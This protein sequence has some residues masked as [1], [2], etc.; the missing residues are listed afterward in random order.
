MCK[1]GDDAEILQ[2]AAN[3]AALCPPA[4]ILSRFVK[5]QDSMPHL[6]AFSSRSLIARG[7]T[8]HHFPAMAGLH[9]RR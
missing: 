7:S 5:S 1:A 3:S 8:L 2:G 9:I 4:I 6:Q